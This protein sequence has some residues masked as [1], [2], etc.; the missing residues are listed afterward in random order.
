MIHNDIYEIFFFFLFFFFLGVLLVG[1][2]FTFTFT[3]TFT[4][5]DMIYSTLPLYTSHRH[6]H[7]FFSITSFLASSC[8]GRTAAERDRKK[9]RRKGRK[10]QFG[11]GTWGELEP[12]LEC[13]RMQSN[14]MQEASIQK[15]YNYRRRIIR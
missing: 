4:P 5:I 1:V 11:M 10:G 7:T 6:T 13:N 8:L 15:P 2:L 14:A 3:F 9:G 12:S